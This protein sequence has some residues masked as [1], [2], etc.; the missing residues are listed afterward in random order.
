MLLMLLLLIFAYMQ[1][2]MRAP[3]LYLW[4]IAYGVAS[5]LLSL[6]FGMKLLGAVIILPIL[7]AYAWAYFWFLRRFGD[8]VFLWAIIAIV[9]AIFPMMIG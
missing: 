9:G 3:K 7:I 2:N 6:A 5:F 1:E 8:N 4:A